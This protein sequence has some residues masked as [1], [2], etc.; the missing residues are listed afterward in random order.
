MVVVIKLLASRELTFRGSNE[1]VGSSPNGKFVEILEDIAR[2]D[3]FVTPHFTKYESLERG[4]LLY[5]SST[6]CHEC[7]SLLSEKVRV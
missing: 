2:F 7:I 1:I 4:S 5:L 3:P 6:L